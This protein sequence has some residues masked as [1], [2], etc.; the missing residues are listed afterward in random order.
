MKIPEEETKWRKKENQLEGG[1]G[2][3]EELWGKG[4]NGNKLQ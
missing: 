2:M 4:R 1:K 3:E